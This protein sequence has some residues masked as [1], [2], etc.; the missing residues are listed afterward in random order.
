MNANMFSISNHASSGAVFSSYRE[1]FSIS[2]P[3]ELLGEERSQMELQYTTIALNSMLSLFGASFGVVG[4]TNAECGVIV[5]TPSS[6]S[7]LP[8][9]QPINPHSSPQETFTT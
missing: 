1:V 7:K 9:R 5:A 6:V 3:K 2:A 8:Q 4:S